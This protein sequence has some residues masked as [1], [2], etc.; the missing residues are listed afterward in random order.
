MTLIATP[1]AANANSYVTVARAKVLL[2]ERLDGADWIAAPEVEQEQSL[3][4]ATRLLEQWVTWRGTPT[5]TVQVLWWPISDAYDMHDI[6][7]SST[8]IP[9]FLER[10]TAIYALALWTYGKQARDTRVKRMDIGPVNIEFVPG[11]KAPQD[12]LP[13]EVRRLLGVYGLITGAGG[14]IPV[15]RV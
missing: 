3:I 9:A 8:T 12:M 15:V 6:L 2:N 4:W 11:G 14:M 5:T 13:A 10:A 1:S 7:L